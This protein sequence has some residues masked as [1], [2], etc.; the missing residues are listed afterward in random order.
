MQPTG[1]A[2]GTLQAPYPPAI[3]IAAGDSAS[4]ASEAAAALENV[5]LLFS[6]TWHW[7]YVYAWL[8]GRALGVPVERELDVAPSPADMRGR[9]QITAEVTSVL[10]RPD[11]KHEMSWAESVLP[12]C[13]GL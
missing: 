8:Y 9:P 4:A 13:V 3:P 6:L 2:R 11:V 12:G 1:I 10:R 7:I 5:E